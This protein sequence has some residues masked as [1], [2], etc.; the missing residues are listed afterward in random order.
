[1]KISAQNF[2]TLA[3]FEVTSLYIEIQCVLKRYTTNQ[4]VSDRQI[5]IAIVEVHSSNFYMPDY[6]PATWNMCTFE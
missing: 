1:M 4:F 3:N 6:V 5:K 2:I